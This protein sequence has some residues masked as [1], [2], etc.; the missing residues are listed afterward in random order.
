MKSSKRKPTKTAPPKGAG[1]GYTLGPRKPKP[2]SANTI[3][4][5][6]NQVRERYGNVSHMWLWRNVRNN[7]A[8]PK[9]TYFGRLMMFSVVELDAYDRLLISKRSG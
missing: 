1:A 7:P 6:S 3:W 4:L 9:P 2:V 5:T 8:F